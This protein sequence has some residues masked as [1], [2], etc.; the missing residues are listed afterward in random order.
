[1]TVEEAASKSTYFK[2][3][4]MIVGVIFTLSVVG[5]ILLSVLGDPI[6]VELTTISTGSLTFLV[7]TTT[8]AQQTKS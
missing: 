3:A 8:A 1:M 5:I 2:Y 6:P 4:L 7:G